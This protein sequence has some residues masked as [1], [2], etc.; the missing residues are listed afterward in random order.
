MQYIVQFLSSVIDYIGNATGN[1]GLA[2]MGLTVAV[3]LVMLPFTIMQA[4]STQAL[5]VMKP[6]MDK[7]N[8]KYKD[9]PERLN[10]ELMELYRKHKVNPASSCIMIAI[11]FPILMAMIQALGFNEALKGASFLGLKLGESGGLPV[12][13][14]AAITT[15]VSV[16]LSPT[17]GGGQAGQSQNVML[18]VMVGLMLFFAW[19]YDVA[20]S[21]YIVTANL[22]GLVE[23]YLVPRPEI[24]P[25]GAGRR[26]KR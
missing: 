11:Q 24:T 1:Y 3:R 9:D 18:I 21:L 10:M 19:K 2:V 23:R 25:E 7:I 14:V 26:E 8:K 12:A 4:R 15:Y 5:N 17:M 16:K 6:E 22:L 20:V 13:A